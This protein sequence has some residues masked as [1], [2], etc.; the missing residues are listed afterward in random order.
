MIDM[1]ESNEWCIPCNGIKTCEVFYPEGSNKPGTLRC[2]SCFNE[3]KLRSYE[4]ASS[5]LEHLKLPIASEEIKSMIKHKM[6]RTSSGDK[7]A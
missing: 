2:E 3:F 7:G 1:Y 5:H 4:E 6:P